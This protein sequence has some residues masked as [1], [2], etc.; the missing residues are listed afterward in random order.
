MKEAAIYAR[1]GAST[2]APQVGAGY[3]TKFANLLRLA[4]AQRTEVVVV[5]TPGVLGDTYDEIVQSLSLLAERGLQ[6]AISTPQPGAVTLNTLQRQRRKWR[7][8]R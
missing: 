2:G 7:N 1:E 6:L 8:R 5:D 3:P 4:R